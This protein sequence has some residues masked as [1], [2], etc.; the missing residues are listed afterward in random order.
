LRRAL[1]QLEA[2]HAPTHHFVA[3][4]RSDL[5]AA[6]AAMGRS[7]EAEPMLVRGYEALA[8]T[9]GEDKPETVRARKH[10]QDFHARSK[11][12]VKG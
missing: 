3:E 4:T 7:A 5:G 10:L 12:G 2:I 6:L 1:A 11:S 8:S 9:V